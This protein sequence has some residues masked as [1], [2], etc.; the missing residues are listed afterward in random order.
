MKDGALKACVAMVCVTAVYGLNMMANAVAGNPLPD[1][2]LLTGVV[3]A[4]CALG[5][6]TVASS[7][8]KSGK[9]A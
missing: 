9:A 8:A 5:G 6:Y 3:G 7:V 2:Y 1:G 4:V